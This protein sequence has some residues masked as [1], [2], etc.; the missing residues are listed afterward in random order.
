MWKPKFGSR[1]HSA[2]QIQS[3]GSGYHRYGIAT[4]QRG[5]FIFGVANCIDDMLI[6]TTLLKKVVPYGKVHMKRARFSASFLIL[7]SIFMLIPGKVHADLSNLIDFENDGPF[8][9]APP[10]S[11]TICNLAIPMYSP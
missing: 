4:V 1:D 3:S 10:A 6:M 7:I 8:P 11:R 2:E 5:M 9:G